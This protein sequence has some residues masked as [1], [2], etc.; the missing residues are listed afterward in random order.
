MNPTALNEGI[1]VVDDEFIILRGLCL[2]LEE[3]G[4]SVIS[5]AATCREAID[6]A[7]TYRPKIVLMDLRLKGDGDGVDAALDIH[8]NVGS[9]VIF[10]TGSREPE[11]IERIEMDH[12]VAI[13]FKPI[14]DA[15]LQ[16]AIHA[17][18][19]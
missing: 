4:L 6:K 1:L 9:K 10:I 15:Q 7:A 19:L 11:A 14:S 8:R 3:M 17:A 18:S 2:Q 16:A 12:P 5:T 13:L